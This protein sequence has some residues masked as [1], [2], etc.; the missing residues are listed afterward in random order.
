MLTLHNRNQEISLIIFDMMLSFSL[1]GIFILSKLLENKTYT[2][3]KYE[4]E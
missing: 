4:V 1:N 2:N 3:S